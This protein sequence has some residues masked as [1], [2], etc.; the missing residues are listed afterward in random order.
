M[1]RFLSIDDC[2]KLY[3]AYSCFVHANDKSTVMSRK[4][5]AIWDDLEAKMT[6][7]RTKN[8]AMNNKRNKKGSAPHEIVVQ[9]LS[10]E[11]DSKQTYRPIQPREFVPFEHE[12]LTSTNL[13]SACV[14]HLNMPPGTCD[15]LVSNK[16]PSCTDTSQIPHRLKDKVLFYT[17]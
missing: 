8:D 15:V 2:T 14:T 1:A 9:K 3:F 13:K 16:G 5:N 11:P 6:G 12:E 17:L 7:K 4:R 10:S